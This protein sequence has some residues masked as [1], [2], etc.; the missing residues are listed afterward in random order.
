MVARNAVSALPSKVVASAMIAE[1]GGTVAS[2]VSAAVVTAM[3]AIINVVAAA[4]VVTG[5]PAIISQLHRQ[6][7]KPPPRARKRPN[8]VLAPSLRPQQQTPQRRNKHC[9]KHSPAT[10]AAMAAAG[11]AVAA[12]NA[13]SAVLMLQANAWTLRNVLIASGIRANL[14]YRNPMRSLQFRDLMLQHLPKK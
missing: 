2:V 11:V 6:T 9:A 14:L 5:N 3:A 10:S 8:N 1:R 7:H 12:A 4:S 13:P